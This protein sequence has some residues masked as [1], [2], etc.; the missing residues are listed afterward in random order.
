LEESR[1]DEFATF[2]NQEMIAN[3]GVIHIQK[4]SGMF[5]AR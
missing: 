4:D 3:D 5:L 2:L 1:R